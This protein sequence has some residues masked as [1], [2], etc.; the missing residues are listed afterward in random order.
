MN[1]TFPTGVLA[2]LIGF[3]RENKK[4]YIIYANVLAALV[5]LYVVAGAPLLETLTIDMYDVARNQIAYSFFFSFMFLL[6]PVF[7]R[8]RGILARPERWILAYAVFLIA[9]TIVLDAVGVFP[10]LNNFNTDY[11]YGRDYFLGK[12]TSFYYPPMCSAYFVFKYIINPWQSTL[13]HRITTDAWGVG[14]YYM[15]LKIAGI[16]DLGIDLSKLNN[17]YLFLS[18]NAIQAFLLPIIQKFDYFIILITLVGIYFALQKRWFWASLFLMYSGF[19]KLYAFLWLGGMLLLLIKQRAW[20]DFKKMCLSTI[21]SA[22]A[23]LAVSFL[24]EGMAFI[25]N[26]LKFGWHYTIWEEAF[27]LNWSYYLKYTGVPGINLLPFILLAAAYLVYMVRYERE[28]S[29][30]FFSNTVIIILLFYPSINYHYIIWILPLIALTL[31]DN[32]KRYRKAIFIY[33]I[34]HV[35]AELHV[36]AW[37]MLLGFESELYLVPGIVPNGIPIILTIKFILVI[38]LLLGLLSFIIL[39]SRKQSLGPKTPLALAP[40]S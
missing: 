21:I 32:V 23:F 12:P 34:I 2:R 17:A 9:S 37:L 24:M 3:L 8:A 25:E 33:E 39:P 26:T 10:G 31:V 40:I 19:F 18:L 6:Y 14:I 1:C 4:F 38:P 28:I 5:V 27:N 11:Y 36:F 15:M 22:T 16:K 29:L 20:P 13:L 30:S 35:N 7:G